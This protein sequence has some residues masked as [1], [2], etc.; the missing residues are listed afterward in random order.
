MGKLMGAWNDAQVA[1]QHHG[2]FQLQKNIPRQIF[3]AKCHG[4]K[5]SQSETSHNL[6]PN[7]LL[8]ITFWL[9]LRPAR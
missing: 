4:R 9:N 7:G 5:L 6:T 1:Q 3:G 2:H 8:L